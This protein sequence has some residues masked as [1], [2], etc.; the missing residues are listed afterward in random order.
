[1]A[2]ILCNVIF[3]FICLQTSYSVSNVQITTSPFGGGVMIKTKLW[4]A[5][6]GS[7]DIALVLDDTKSSRFC[8]GDKCTAYYR[9]CVPHDGE[10][11]CSL[12]LTGPSGL[13]TS[14]FVFAK[15][16]VNLQAA[17]QNVGI[18]LDE[19]DRASAVPLS[20]FNVEDKAETPPLCRVHILDGPVT[21]CDHQSN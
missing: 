6:F 15:P 16:G 21:K 3:G 2:S 9:H 19:N 10:Q 14:L 5:S 1:M 4:K 8:R 7:G 11:R 12:L 13:A 17:L 20:D 18:L